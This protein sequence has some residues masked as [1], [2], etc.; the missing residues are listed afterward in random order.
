MVK[1]RSAS[2]TTTLLC[3]STTTPFGFPTTWKSA[4]HPLAY[5]PLPLPLISPSPITCG[6]LKE[7]TTTLFELPHDSTSM[8]SASNEYGDDSRVTLFYHGH[9]Q[10]SWLDSPI[11]GRQGKINKVLSTA[12]V[13]AVVLGAGQGRPSFRSESVL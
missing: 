3:W 10:Q 13:H 2:A 4:L 7:R 12:L 11:N 1:R 6:L 8:D 5:C 9:S